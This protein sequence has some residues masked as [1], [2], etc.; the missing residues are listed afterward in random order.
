[1]VFW[2]YLILTFLLG[3]EVG[4]IKNEKKIKISIMAPNDSKIPRQHWD[5]SGTNI[6]TK[7]KL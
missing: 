1:M 4:M 2:M 3:C 5:V 6:Q 7:R